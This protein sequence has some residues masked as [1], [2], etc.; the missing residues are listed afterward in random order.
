MT[1]IN[2]REKQLNKYFYNL[3]EAMQSIF[4]PEIVKFGKFRAFY[5][6]SAHLTIQFLIFMEIK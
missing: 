5:R 2:L 1:Q 6:S 4:S 3:S